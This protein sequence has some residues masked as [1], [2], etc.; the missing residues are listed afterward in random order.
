MCGVGASTRAGRRHGRWVVLP[1]G[2][3]PGCCAT[4]TRTLELWS[5]RH[6]GGGG[7]VSD[8]RCHRTFSPRG[9][10]GPNAAARRVKLSGPHSN[11]ASLRATAARRGV[12]YLLAATVL[13]IAVGAAGMAS[14]ESPASLAQEGVSGGRPLDGY[15]DALWWTA[16]AMTTGATHQPSTPEGR[17]LGWLLS[18]YGLAVF[19]YLT[20]TLASHFVGR[21]REDAGRTPTD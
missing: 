3:A 10:P 19:G 12:G 20:A 2:A 16:Y 15:A 4:G 6:V 1:E 14:F 5:C 9:A 8:E 21:E 11:P 13:V 7:Q 18:L 17:L